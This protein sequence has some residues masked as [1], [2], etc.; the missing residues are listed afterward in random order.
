MVTGLGER[1]HTIQILT[2]TVGRAN[3]PDFLK[4]EFHHFRDSSG[5]QQWQVE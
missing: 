5:F 2:Q 3:Q 1:I 4:F